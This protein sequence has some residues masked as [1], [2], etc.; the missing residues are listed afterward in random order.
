MKKIS[1]SIAAFA[2]LAS[3]A[4]GVG[5]IAL[6]QASATSGTILVGSIMPLSGAYAD[7]GIAAGNSAELAVQQINAAGGILGKKL[8]IKYADDGASA[9][10]SAL[11]FKKYMSEGAVA[12]LGSG[13]T[14][15]TTVALADQYKFPDIGLIDD[16]G[17]A[18]YP[19]G[20][21]KAPYPWAWSTSPNGYAVG[22]SLGS[23]AAANCANGLYVIHD[24]TYYGVGGLTGMQITYTKTL[25][26]N[27]SLDEN[28]S[29]SQPA[30]TILTAEVQK[31][32]A[33][34]ASCVDV[35][36]TAQDQAVFAQQLYA[37]GENG[38]ITMLG[39]DVTGSDA[40]FA[41]A[42]G[43]TDLKGLTVVSSFLKT[44]VTPPAN[45]T[46]FVAKYTKT[47]GKD[48]S[49][50]GEVQYDG[51]MILAEAIK[52][53]GSTKPA[54]I[55]AQLDK[56]TN[57]QGLTGVLTFTKMQH[58]TIN[59]PQ[60]QNVVLSDSTTNKWVATK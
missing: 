24:N 42:A 8:V 19:N 45:L 53:A 14:A 5:G 57:H 54:A 16:G 32:I 11:L 22:E 49:V 60:F 29:S 18:I 30:A 31:V 2:V 26:G 20:P 21:T 48:P 51:V 58:T 56:I 41:N 10:T 34:G 25:K 59:G 39:N 12:I 27:D 47:Y 35:W 6:S 1:K 44:S 50:W 33:S 13:D 38:K 23:Y 7:I 46:S 28:W 15:S 17:S 4:I 3:T 40:T 37:A 52:K 55:A 36:L 43:A 9:T